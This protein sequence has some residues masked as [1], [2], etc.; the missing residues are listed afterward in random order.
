M[1]ELICG[2]GGLFAPVQNRVKELTQRYQLMALTDE[3]RRNYF[4]GNKA[5]TN[6][7]LQLRLLDKHG[8]ISPSEENCAGVRGLSP[9]TI[10]NYLYGIR[11]W[12]INLGL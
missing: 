11:S 4:Q 6:F 2:G 1:A 7:S 9:S 10:H 5:F 3:T 8:L 12:S